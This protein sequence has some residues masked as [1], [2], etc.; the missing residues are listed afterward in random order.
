MIYSGIC[1]IHN[2]TVVEC[3]IGNPFKKDKSVSVKV[4]FDSKK[5]DDSES[6][7]VFNVFAN[8]TSREVGEKA[9]AVLRATVIR[10]AELSIK[11]Y[12][13]IYFFIFF[14]LLYYYYY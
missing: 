14:I 10:R 2:D 1:K 13:Y 8:S 7:L 5:L 9:P 4:K 6:Q 11:G 3:S 12:I